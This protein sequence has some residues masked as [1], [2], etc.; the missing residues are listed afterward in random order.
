MLFIKEG[1]IV[2]YLI[3]ISSWV[4]IFDRSRNS[5]DLL[6][7]KG[8]S[9]INQNPR[10]ASSTRQPQFLSILSRGRGGTCMRSGPSIWDLRAT[11]CRFRV[12]HSSHGCYDRERHQMPADC[13]ISR[14][15]GTSVCVFSDC[16]IY[17]R[18]E[19]ERRIVKYLCGLDDCAHESSEWTV[20]FFSFFI[21]FLHRPDF[22]INVCALAN[23]SLC[24]ML[25]VNKHSLRKIKKKLLHKVKLTL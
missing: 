12:A 23:L 7:T 17:R 21:F 20:L 5:V 3:K 13:G 9:K 6:Q 2:N 19:I 8:I 1:R 14:N 24:N 22:I 18:A 15:A 11:G 16:R 10:S 25:Q 4:I